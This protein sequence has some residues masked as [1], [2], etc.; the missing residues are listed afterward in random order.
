[1][2]DHLRKIILQKGQKEKEKLSTSEY[3]QLLYHDC[4]NRLAAQEDIIVISIKIM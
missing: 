3:T 1:M 2:N 4:E